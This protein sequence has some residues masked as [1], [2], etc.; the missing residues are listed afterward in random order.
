MITSIAQV[1]LGEDRRDPMLLRYTTVKTNSSLAELPASR[2]RLLTPRGTTQRATMSTTYGTVDSSETWVIRQTE[3]LPP[4]DVCWRLM[5]DSLKPTQIIPAME[6]TSSS[7][8]TLHMVN[9]RKEWTVV[10]SI[11]SHSLKMTA[12]AMRCMTA[13]VGLGTVSIRTI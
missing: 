2:R 11:A 10:S 12:D 6:T 5:P 13:S 3:S 7:V 9:V 4:I 8:Y 1:G